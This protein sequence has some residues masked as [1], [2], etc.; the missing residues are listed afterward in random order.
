MWYKAQ[1]VLKSKTNFLGKYNFKT[2]I[3]K[4]IFCIDMYIVGKHKAE[5]FHVLH[6]QCDA[7]KTGKKRL[8]STKKC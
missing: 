7:Q 4:L 8:Q 3:G 2:K 5:L 6:F 1:V